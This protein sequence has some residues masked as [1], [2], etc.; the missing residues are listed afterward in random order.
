MISLS[1]LL[2]WS[3]L[4]VSA[5]VAALQADRWGA[6]LITD[7]VTRVDTTVRPFVVETEEVTVRTHSI[8]LATGATARRLGI[9]SEAEFWGR[10]ISACAI[11]DGASPQFKGQ[12]VAVV[13]GGA[14]ATRCRAG[15]T[16][17]R[18]HAAPPVT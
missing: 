16:T 5:A 4:D 15:H 10:G 14:P 17:V 2:P 7:D 1:T 9:P 8:I 12:E 13:G 11:C 18:P 3:A 6:E